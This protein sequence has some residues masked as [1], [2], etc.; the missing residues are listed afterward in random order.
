MKHLVY[1]ICEKEN[2][3]RTGEPVEGVA[4]Y[5]VH[6]VEARGLAAAVSSVEVSGVSAD[7][8]AMTS[9]HAVIDHFHSRRTVIPLRF[10]TLLDNELEVERLLQNHEKRYKRLLEELQGRIEMG[11]RVIV[12][13]HKR[14]P[15][16]LSASVQFS[17][18]PRT[19]GLSYLASVKARH[20]TDSQM[21]EKNSKEI[22]AYSAPF[23]G[24]YSKAKS[25][26]SGFRQ[27]NN[28]PAT[29]LSLYFLIPRDSLEEF[30]RA[31]GRLKSR[32]PAKMLLSG[33]WPPY[34]FV[35]LS[36]SPPQG[37]G[38]LSP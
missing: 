4:G 28:E 29:L 24:I 26:T 37:S 10:G 33:P 21:A 35:L 11:I 1:C 18:E 19:P 23:E 20:V 31:F 12:P 7:I 14:A 27:N 17:S 6:E 30:R 15:E 16:T 32:E 3:R 8:A 38:Y 22:R 2:G 36:D 13:Y 25:E 5:L 9:Y 34:N